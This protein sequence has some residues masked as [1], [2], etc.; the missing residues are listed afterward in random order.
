MKIKDLRNGMKKVDVEAKVISMDAAREVTSRFRNTTYRV[1]SAIVED[2][3]GQIKL[4]LWDD[5][6]EQVKLGDKVTIDSGFVTSF[7]GE[8]QLNIGKF[9]TL[10]VA[11]Q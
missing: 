7:R 6:I 11:S 2:D 5:H 1:A 4:T 9:G 3:S 10:T 8:I